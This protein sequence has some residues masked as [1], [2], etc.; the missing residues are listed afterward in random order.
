MEAPF[1]DNFKM[2]NITSYD[3]KDDPTAYVE[4]FWSWMDF[5]RVSELVRCQAF[6]LTLLWLA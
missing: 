4:A 2:P 5:K 3:G 1:L 6:P